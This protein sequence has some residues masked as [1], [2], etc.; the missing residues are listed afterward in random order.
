MY[1][2]GDFY[3]REG[4][5]EGEGAGTSKRTLALVTLVLVLALIGVGVV[6]YFL[7]LKPKW[8]AQSNPQPQPPPPPNG[9]PP[10]P[11]QPQPPVTGGTF[12]REMLVCNRAWG[13]ANEKT[14]LGDAAVVVL[15]AFD[16]QA[17]AV[18]ALSAQGK[19][20]IGYISAG[21][22]ENWR[23]DK[24]KFP[25]SAVGETMNGWKGEK[26]IN[27]KQWSSLKP[28]MTDRL[29][30]VKGK[31]FRAVEFDN[32]SVDSKAGGKLRTENLAYIQWLAETAHGLGLLAV[33]KN[34]PQY[35]SSTVAW[36]DALIT[37][38]AV[39]FP[40][41]AKQYAA[42]KQAGKPVWDFE[43]DPLK[44]KNKVDMSIFSDVS[45]ENSSKGWVRQAR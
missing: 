5:G 41:D 30:M 22:T 24:D 35:A 38:D 45:L 26:W 28:V 23:P 27:L 12:T 21:S 43:Y 39:K 15:D 1:P 33:M 36:C 44:N 19:L 40:D 10:N 2:Y 32:A 37:E 16:A 3:Y 4:E 34:G 9:G 8:Q 42:Y 6:V 18:A 13:K 31:G 14:P 20:V 17:S 29:K 25:P 11:P 7:V